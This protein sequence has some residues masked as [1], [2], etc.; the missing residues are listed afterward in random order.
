ML[1]DLD[2][3]QAYGV[4]S[5]AMR[6]RLGDPE[7]I[8][9]GLSLLASVAAD[10]EDYVS[11]E[12]MYEEAAALGRGGDAQ[13]RAMLTGSLADVAMRQRDYERALTLGEESLELFRKLARDDGA[14][15][16]L[17][18]VALCLF[19]MDRADDAIAPARECLELAYAI[20][21]VENIVW[22]LLLLGA[23]TTRRGDVH[24]AVTIVGAA[25]ALRTRSGLMLVGAEAELRE[26][27]FDE[28]QAS[29]SPRTYEAAFA[30]G[31]TMSLDEAVEYALASID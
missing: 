24:S 20:V 5:L 28:L 26:T 13:T 25:E 10:R 22:A 8:A 17:F 1:G 9:H 2:A 23:M 12:Q 31:R 30:G 4:E 15:W 19:R 16:A 21:E 29:L 11:A 27:A 3:A 14:A 18:T 6:R 7:E